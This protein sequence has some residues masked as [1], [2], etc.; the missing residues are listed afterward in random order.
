MYPND[1]LKVIAKAGIDLESRILDIGCG[2]GWLPSLLR[3][4]GIN[5]VVPKI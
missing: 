3:N 2:S 5:E 1:G 4:A